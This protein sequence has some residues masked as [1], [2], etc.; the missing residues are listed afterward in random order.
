[1]HEP[2]MHAG[3]NSM[4]MPVTVDVQ[5][6]QTLVKSKNFP[7]VEKMVSQ[8]VRRLGLKIVFGVHVH[9][10]QFVAALFGIAYFSK[11]NVTSLTAT[12]PKTTHQSTRSH[13]RAPGYR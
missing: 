9:V 8:N 1:M 6:L 13:P 3:G 5:E 7:A 2:H 11:A 12:Q 4:D 10:T